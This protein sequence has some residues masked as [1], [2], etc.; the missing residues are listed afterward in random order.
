MKKLP[1][2]LPHTKNEYGWQKLAQSIDPEATIIVF[3]DTGHYWKEGWW[4][5]ARIT[6]RTWNPEL[7]AGLKKLLPHPGQPTKDFR[8]EEIAPNRKEK[9]KLIGVGIIRFNSVTPVHKGRI[10]F[11]YNWKRFRTDV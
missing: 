8:V 4:T 9:S 3:R 6:I 5:H 11:L 1:K 7:F 10:R 2:R